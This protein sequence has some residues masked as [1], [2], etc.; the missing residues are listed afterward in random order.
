MTRIRIAFWALLVGLL[1]LRSIVVDST[2][3][4]GSTFLFAMPLAS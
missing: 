3:G 4:E 2:V 1:A